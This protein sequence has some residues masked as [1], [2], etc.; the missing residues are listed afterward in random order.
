MN[1]KDLQALARIRALDAKVLLAAQRYAGAYY[2]AG[3]AVECGLKACIA[4]RVGLHDFPD[5][6]LALDSF[7]HSPVKLLATAGLAQAHAARLNAS[8]AFSANWAIVKDWSETKRYDKSIT[9]V[10]AKDMVEA[11][12]A[13]G[14]GVLSWLRSVW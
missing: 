1:R 3:Y 11:V 8:P 12:T 4:K 13:R 5:K 10:S 9:A 14:V 2:L 7:N 6:Q